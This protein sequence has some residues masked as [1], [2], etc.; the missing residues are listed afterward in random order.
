[1]EHLL[2]IDNGTQSVRA[3]LFD[4]A[5]N[6]LHGHRVPFT[7]YVSPQPGWA[8]QDPDVFWNAVGQACRALWHAGADP[9]AV[10]AVAVTTQRGT[11]VN[12]DA[13]GQALRPAI[14]WLDQRRTE[15]VAPVRGPFGAAARLIGL[16]GMLRY[17]QA[18]TEANWISRHEPRVWAATRH[19]V[20]L[21]GFLNYRLTG[22]VR[23]SSGSQVGFL[24]FDYR[25]H[26]WARPG[27]WHWQ[28]APFDASALPDLVPPGG[29]IGAV[30]RAASEHTGVPV[31]TPVIA[32]AADKACEVLGSGATGPSV[33]CLSYGT[34]A[35]YTVTQGT[36][37]EPRAFIPPY[38][39]AMPGAFNLEV[40]L[41]RGYWMVS[42]FKQE[43][44]QSEQR[45]AAQRG[46]EAE[47]LFD[48]LLASVPPGSMG[49]TLQPYW[50]P[51]LK[52]PG[53]EAKGAIIGFGDVHT[54][55]HLY[56]AI[57]EGLAYGLRAGKEHVERRTRVPVQDLRV[58]GGGSRSDA[59]MQITADVFGIPVARPHVTE[60]S[61]LGAAIS[62]AV[63][64]G[65]HGSYE[66]A[67]RAMTRRGRVF[68][69]NAAAARV[70]DD[71]YSGVYRRMYGRLRP[72]YARIRAITNYPPRP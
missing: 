12:L 13:R 18:E 20:L 28:L 46:V 63:G 43:F 29:Q 41:Y 68:E 24:P 14:V 21:S 53:P 3:L 5:G 49:L 16:G 36:Y 58:A 71:L 1:M 9:R 52:E 51:G 56:R 2:A 61:G 69:P 30:T 11:V 57:I 33:G 6:L 48:D 4:A 67:V 19:Y 8:E 47:D 34:T 59:V 54:R 38:P 55:A 10:R 44:G 50:T 26:A 70:Y 45:L 39:S 25:R 35:T 72:L 23:D 17:L 60:A 31:G 32:A 42:W 64:T 62:A 37:R 40:Q 65:L 27:S 66:D 15:N 7:P 22:E